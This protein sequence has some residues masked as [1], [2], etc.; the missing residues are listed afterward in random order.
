MSAT[1]KDETLKPLILA[2]QGK[3][4]YEIVIGAKA[5][6]AE[7]YAA[8]ELAYFLTEMTGAEFGIRGDDG[9]ASDF[10]IVLGNTN[11]M[12]LDELGPELKPQAWEGFA[13]VRDGEK[14]LILGNIP[15]ATLYGVYDFLYEELGCRFLTPEV[16]HVPSKATLSIALASRSYDPPMEY[17][18]IWNGLAH[19][20]QHP[21]SPDEKT[22]FDDVWAVRNHLNLMGSSAQMEVM[23]GKV[24]WVGPSFVHTFEYFIP[25]EEYFDEH[26]E[27]FAEIDGKR[28]REHDGQI[29]SFTRL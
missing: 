10:E 7:K 24:K 1:T 5:C 19:Q 29:H 8:K 22:M 4:R 6:E 13:I 16:N 18:E 21:H 27:Y 14:L 12:R 28:I 26:P 9:E 20:P 15:R 2:E 17:R 23:L 25:V 3:T 11:R